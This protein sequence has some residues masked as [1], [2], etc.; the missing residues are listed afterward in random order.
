MAGASESTR[1]IR[2]LPDEGSSSFTGAEVT[3][4]QTEAALGI[5]ISNETPSG[6]ITGTDGTD[7]NATFT[8]AFAPTSTSVIWLYKNG[9]LQTYGSGNDYTISSLTITFNSGAIPLAGDSLRAT[10]RK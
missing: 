7:G 8:L 10:Y 9:V 4:V 2:T 1:G 5:W 3:W 6:A